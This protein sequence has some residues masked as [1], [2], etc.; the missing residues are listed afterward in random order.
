MDIPFLLCQTVNKRLKTAGKL[1]EY[2]SMFLASFS[3]DVAFLKTEEEISMTLPIYT[4]PHR[5]SLGGVN[6]NVM[7]LLSYLAALIVSFVPFVGRV[8]WIAPLIIFF[9]EKESGLVRFHAMQA[10]VIQLLNMVINGIASVLVGGTF[11]AA[12]ISN[13]GIFALGSWGIGIVLSLLL[14]IV[15]LLILIFSIIAMVKA[16]RYQVYE[17][18]GIGRLT[19]FFL[20][21]IS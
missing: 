6:A 9:A 14:G 13:L 5:S 19:R 16:Y 15:S 2:D 1:S 3:V 10:F 7:A 11:F 21:K 18:V 12:S 4:Q 8:S 17:I 20:S